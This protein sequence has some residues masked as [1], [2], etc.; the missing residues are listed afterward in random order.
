MTSEEIQYLLKIC[1]S[2]YSCYS[3]YLTDMYSQSWNILKETEQQYLAILSVGLPNDAKR[4]VVK[5][6]GRH[7]K[8]IYTF[9]THVEEELFP[10]SFTYI[11]WDLEQSKD[12]PCLLI[13]PNSP[14]NTST[15]SFSLVYIGPLRTNQYQEEERIKA[16]INSA[17]QKNKHV[18]IRWCEKFYQ[19]MYKYFDKYKNDAL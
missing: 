15:P 14:M 17:T 13:Q 5:T 11:C 6:F 12:V 8:F 3:Q 2:L 16:Q 7:I 1:D 9:W 4:L 19:T 10:I 18:L